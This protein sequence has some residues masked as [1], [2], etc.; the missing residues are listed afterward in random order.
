MRWKSKWKEKSGMLYMLICYVCIKHNILL[1]LPITSFV[2]PFLLIFFSFSKFINK[3]FIGFGLS[4]SILGPTE[5]F[6]I[7]SN[8]IVSDFVMVSALYI[9]HF[10]GYYYY[11]VVS[12]SLNVSDSDW[13]EE[14]PEFDEFTYY[15]FGS[16][17]FVISLTKLYIQRVTNVVDWM[18]LSLFTFY[19]HIESHH[20]HE[21]AFTLKRKQLQWMNN[22]WYHPRFLLISHFWAF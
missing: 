3:L 22:T 1:N 10:S 7:I 15:S 16:T 14:W 19:R 11:V 12:I 6:R 18:E 4:T 8:P 21:I 13:L 2:F 20:M 17:F 5:C 9:R